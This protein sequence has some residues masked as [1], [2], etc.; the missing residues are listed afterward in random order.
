[1]PHRDRRLAIL[2]SLAYLAVGVA[3][4][5]LGPAVASTMPALWAAAAILV[6]LAHIDLAS[7]GL[8]WLMPAVVGPIA[9]FPLTLVPGT[10]PVVLLAVLWP[11]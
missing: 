7:R 11:L 1:M 3:A 10:V 9:L 4:W 5:A 6:I 2:A 8:D